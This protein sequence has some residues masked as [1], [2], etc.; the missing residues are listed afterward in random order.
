MVQREILRKVNCFSTGNSIYFM[1]CYYNFCL[2]LQE[3]IL[4][5]NGAIKG[6]GLQ[7]DQSRILIVQKRIKIDFWGGFAVRIAAASPSDT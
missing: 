7:Y 2:V 4:R 1:P 6:I 3:K 5:R